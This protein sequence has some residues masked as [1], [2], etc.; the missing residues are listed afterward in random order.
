MGLPL[1]DAALKGHQGVR[2][3][4]CTM[5]A[6]EL[7]QGQRPALLRLF[8]EMI[9]VMRDELRTFKPQVEILSCDAMLIKAPGL[10]LKRC[11][12]G[13]RFSLQLGRA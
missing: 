9:R 2:C 1:Q 13:E 12:F 11:R 4:L 6:T 3:L 8:A 5:L 10:F 7:L